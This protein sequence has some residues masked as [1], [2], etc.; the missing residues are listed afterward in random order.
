ALRRS[1]RAAGGEVQGR[2]SGGHSLPHRR[3]QEG[4][5]GGRGRA[6]GAALARGGQDQGR[7]GGGPGGR[8]GDA[9]AQRSQGVIEARERVIVAL[10]VP[11]LPALETFLD[12]LDGQPLFYKVG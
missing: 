8:A 12:R 7:R 1:R 9:R 5:G 4:R 2:G 11:D 6:Q 3:G 10:D